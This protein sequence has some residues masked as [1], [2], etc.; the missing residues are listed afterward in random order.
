M[1]ETQDS[2]EV[3]EVVFYYP[4]PVWN[5]GEWIKTLILFFDGVALLVPEYMEDYPRSVDPVITAGLDQHGLLHILKPEKVVD[6]AAT[7]ALATCLADVLASGALDGLS[8]D[9]TVFGSLSNSRLGFYGDSGLA[10]M[11]LGELKSRELARDS[12]DGVS[13]PMHREVRSLILVLLSQILRPQGTALGLDLSPATDQPRLIRGL[14]ELLSVP[15][16]PSAGHVVSFDLN[17]VGV[18]LSS[19]PFDEVLDFRRAHLKEHR[20]YARAIRRAL[21]ELS[22]LSEGEREE[23]FADRQSEIDDLAS[24]LRRISRKAWK[25]PA[26]FSLSVAGA[27]WS[28]VHSNPISAALG[29]GGT[30]LRGIGREKHEAGAYTY[31]FRASDAFV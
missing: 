30:I 13:I 28:L 4:G 16:A 15:Q 12:E 10:E 8:R 7:E 20:A 29:L 9:G 31:V 17:A 27:V 23:F 3:P 14:K 5:S 25:K 11:L 19:V 21:R 6:R 1:E 18:D 24:D 22:P 2:V 26:G